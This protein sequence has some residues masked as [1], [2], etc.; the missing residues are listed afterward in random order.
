MSEGCST[1]I[2]AASTVEFVARG[3]SNNAWSVST[4]LPNQISSWWAEQYVFV[5][6]G[7]HAN[8]TNSVFGAV[9][10]LYPQSTYPGASIVGSSTVTAGGVTHAVS[11]CSI[12]SNMKL[13]V[14]LNSSVSY[15][16]LYVFK[17]KAPEG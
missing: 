14:N 1:K 4:I 2:T 15:N 3:T 5:Y 16:V 9:G 12:D 11:S 7:R 17:I 6:M 10:V 8:S 13:T